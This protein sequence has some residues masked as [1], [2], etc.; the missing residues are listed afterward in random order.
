MTASFKLPFTV[1]LSAMTFYPP[2]ALA[3]P[4]II[5]EIQEHLFYPQEVTVPANK[6]VKLTF[7]N[8]DGTPEEI[9]SFALNREKVIFARS[10]GTIFIGPLQPGEYPFFGEYH[11]NKA[12]G[13]VI[14]K[15]A[16]E[17]ENVN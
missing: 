12:V 14:V 13:K 17:T 10:K 5:V 2:Y 1:L 3:L 9:D 8:H 7:I 16:Q 6:K 11:P 4:E 15:P